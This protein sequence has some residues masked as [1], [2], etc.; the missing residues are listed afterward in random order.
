[1]K[2]Y[3]LITLTLLTIFTLLTLSC[4]GK[5][6]GKPVADAGGPYSIDEVHNDTEQDRQ[7][8]LDGSGSRSLHDSVEH[9]SWSIASNYLVNAF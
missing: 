5:Q 2:P 7:L 9:Y 6:E 3:T 8:V 1:M 4:G